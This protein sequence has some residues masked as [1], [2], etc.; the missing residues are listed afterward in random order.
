MLSRD[1]PKQIS[2]TKSADKEKLRGSLVA[3]LAPGQIFP[4]RNSHPKAAKVCKYPS[5]DGASPPGLS[6]AKKQQR[7]L[8]LPKLPRFDTHTRAKHIAFG[9]QAAPNWDRRGPRLLSL[10]F[11]KPCDGK[12]SAH[13]MKGPGQPPGRMGTQVLD[14][15]LQQVNTS[16]A[17]LGKFLQYMR[18]NL[19]ISNFS[20]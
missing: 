20:M 6:P 9:A 7:F 14:G 18:C 5:S 3:T 17:T 15:Q 16:N 1:K 11:A 8:Q 12:I 10:C 4:F 19:E 13:G 2:I